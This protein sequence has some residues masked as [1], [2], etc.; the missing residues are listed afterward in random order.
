VVSVLVL[1]IENVD[2]PY[3]SCLQD[4]EEDKFFDAP[5]AAEADDRL[6]V[7]G[8]KRNVSSVSVNEAQELTTTPEDDLL[9]VSRDRTMSVSVMV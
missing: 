7:L 2:C 8:H 9:P 5:E 3:H 4:E 6:F 1:A